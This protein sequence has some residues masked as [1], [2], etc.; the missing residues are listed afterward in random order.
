MG[1]YRDDVLGYM[2]LPRDTYKTILVNLARLARID[3]A[4]RLANE[5]SD[6]LTEHA[7]NSWVL[8]GAEVAPDA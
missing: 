8:V 6:A 4:R 2:L 1:E 3:E 7:P 5:S